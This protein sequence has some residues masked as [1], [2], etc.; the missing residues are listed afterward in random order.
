MTKRFNNP[1]S[2]P[3]GNSGFF[4]LFRTK[5]TLLSIEQICSSEGHIEECFER[6]IF[7][8]LVT[9]TMIPNLVFFTEPL[10]GWIPTPVFGVSGE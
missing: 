8:P 1:F 5:N 3:D 4:Y 7:V 6:Y 10:T 9:D 2:E